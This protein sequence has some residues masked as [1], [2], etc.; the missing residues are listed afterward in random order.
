[1]R[2]MNQERIADRSGF[3]LLEVLIVIGILVL[4]AGLVVPAVMRRGELAK[5][6]TTKLDLQALGRSLDLFRHDVGRYPT[7]DEGLKAL[8][9]KPDEEKVAAKWKGKYIE[10]LKGDPWGNAYVYE[11]AE[12]GEVETLDEGEGAAATTALG[13]YKLYSKGPDGEADTD[14]DI[15]AATG[16]TEPTDDELLE[17][18]ELGE[19]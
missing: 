2:S 8:V 1:M 6:D 18:G 16:A 12:A 17:D 10:R 11:F 19:L 14:D 7:T 15:Q 5:I 13:A 9:Q 4:I 3:T